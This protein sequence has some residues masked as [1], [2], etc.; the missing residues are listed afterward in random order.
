MIRYCL[1]RKSAFAHWY[2]FYGRQNIFHSTFAIPIAVHKFN[3]Y[4]GLLLNLVCYC[5]I[6]TGIRTFHKQKQIAY[7]IEMRTDSPMATQ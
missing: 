3:Q 7:N 4:I 5:P 1:A 2:S 6:A